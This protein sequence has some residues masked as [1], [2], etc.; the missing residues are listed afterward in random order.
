MFS[1]SNLNPNSPTGAA[2]RRMA[3]RPSGF[4]LIELL[5]VIALIAILSALLFPALMKVRETAR[6]TSCKNNLSQIGKAVTMYMDDWDDTYPLAAYEDTDGDVVG[7]L[8]PYTNQPYGKGIWR[9]PS[10]DF[11]FE[12]G[13]TSS[14]GYNW[15]YLL[16]PGP[17]YPHTGFSGFY[18]SGITL[19]DLQR[20]SDTICFMDSSAPPPN[21]HLWSYV[22]RPGDPTNNNGMGRPHFRHNGRPNALFCDGHVKAIPR[23]ANHPE[24]EAKYWD[25]RENGTEAGL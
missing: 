9:C 20:P 21:T 11:L 17:K 3:G 19:S 1:L 8:Q 23:D 7:I 13:W 4:T 5:V 24:Q 12:N 25:P 14:Y 10:H 15:E 22:V 16:E 18:N 2:K 6:S